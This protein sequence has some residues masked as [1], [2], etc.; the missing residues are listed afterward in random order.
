M[1]PLRSGPWKKN[2]GYLSGKGSQEMPIGKRGREAGKGRPPAY[3]MLVRQLPWEQLE[4]GP[5]GSSGIQGRLALR[6]LPMREW[7]PGLWTHQLLDVIGQWLLWDSSQ[8][9]L[10]GLSYYNMSP[11]FYSVRTKIT[12]L[13][14]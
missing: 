9:Y 11:P 2:A 8:L 14:L 3:Q 10:W 5:A 13:S 7:G 6:T 4:L 1:D 12:F